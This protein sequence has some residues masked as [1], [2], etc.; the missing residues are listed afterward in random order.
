MTRTLR[1]GGMVREGALPA[2]VAPDARVSA[3]GHPL[4]GF[5]A[6]LR[7]KLNEI[8]HFTC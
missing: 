3:D 2:A 4:P 1:T 6:E 8:R 7:R 5:R